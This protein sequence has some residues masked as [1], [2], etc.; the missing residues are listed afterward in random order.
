MVAITFEQCINCCASTSFAH[1][2]AASSPFRDFGELIDVARSI[3]WRE[4]GITDWLEAFAAHPKIGEKKAAKEVSKQF[5]DF[6][7]GEQQAAAQSATSEIEAQLKSWNEKYHDK[8][9]F[10]FIIYAK[11]QR[12]RCAS[13]R[14]ESIYLLLYCPKFHSGNSY[15][16]PTCLALILCSPLG[17]TGKELTR[18][19]PS[20]QDT[21][22]PHA[23]GGASGSCTGADEDH[24]AASG[25]PFQFI[26]RAGAATENSAEGRSGL[27]V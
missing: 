25:Q 6:S 11:V 27:C 26:C 19:P 10:I 5:G 12:E 8:F 1:K 9:G 15:P 7:S 18:N 22:P 3:W 16:K 4:I 14:E 2:V 13:C 24:R 20:P 23:S 21:I 17:L